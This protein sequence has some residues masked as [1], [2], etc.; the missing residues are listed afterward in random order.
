LRVQVG[1]SEHFP[2]VLD[3]TGFVTLSEGN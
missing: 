1:K 2:I 3:S